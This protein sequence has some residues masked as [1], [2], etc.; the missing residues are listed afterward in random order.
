MILPPGARKLALT[1]H[2]TTSLGWLGAVVAFVALA[3]AGLVSADP[4]TVR[5]VYLAMDLATTTVIVPFALASLVTGIVLSLGTRWGLFRHYW[6]IVKLGITALA[7]AILLLHTQ[8][9][10]TMAQ[11]AADIALTA[12]D[13]RQLRVQ[14]LVDASLAIAALLVTTVLAVYKPAGMTGYGRRQRGGA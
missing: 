12:R 1:V 13:E 14:L 3:A 11:V 8:P 4:K 5:A 6:V 2:L 10:A 7:T 9:I